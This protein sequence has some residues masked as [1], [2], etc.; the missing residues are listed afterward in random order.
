MVNFLHATNLW[1]MRSLISYHGP[2]R[3]EDEESVEEEILSDVLAIREAQHDD[4]SFIQE[5]SWRRGNL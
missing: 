3:R 4:E 5:N 2:D 1:D